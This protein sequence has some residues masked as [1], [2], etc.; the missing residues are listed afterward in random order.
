MC[1]T[2]RKNGIVSKINLYDAKKKSP[3][4]FSTS[5]TTYFDRE[6]EI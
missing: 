1:A 6:D 2:K 5:I 4:P 3:S